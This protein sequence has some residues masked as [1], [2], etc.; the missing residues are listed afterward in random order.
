M[1]ITPEKDYTSQSIILNLTIG[2]T[3]KRCTLDLTYRDRTDKWYCSLTNMQTGEVYLMNVPILCSYGKVA[4]NLWEPYWSKEIGMLCCF[5]IAPTTT[6][7][8]KNN[9][10]EFLLVWGDGNV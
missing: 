2:N 3:T 5:P 9:F 7:P 4:N 10:D 6:D 8:S 1:V